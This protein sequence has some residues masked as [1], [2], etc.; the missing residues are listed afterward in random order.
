MKISNNSF[1]LKLG[2][3]ALFCISAFQILSEKSHHDRNTVWKGK[4][5][6][7]C[8]LA[9]STKI[10]NTKIIFKK[11]IK[12]FQTGLFCVNFFYIC[13]IAIYTVRCLRIYDTEGLTCN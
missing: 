3:E 9:F 13:I 2:M 6:V 12:N 4:F 1:F 5:V 7:R 8:C 11:E 10:S